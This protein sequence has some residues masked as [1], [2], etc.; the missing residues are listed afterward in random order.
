VNDVWY[1]ADGVNWKKTDMDPLWLGREDHQ[2]LVFKD[3]IWVY[4]GMDKDWVWT[5]DVW[6]SSL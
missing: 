2:A 1:T 6:Y 3:R 5:N 4:T